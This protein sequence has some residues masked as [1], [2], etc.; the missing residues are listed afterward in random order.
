MA[1][2]LACIAC[3]SVP[4]AVFPLL[5]SDPPEQPEQ[6]LRATIFTSHGNYGSTTFDPGGRVDAEHIRINVCDNCL[7][8]AAA[9]GRVMHASVVKFEH[10][11]YKYRTW[12]PYSEEEEED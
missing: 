9:Q 6:P 11:T 1:P 5:D 3:G 2:P 7:R 12:E 8:T 10:A 4:K